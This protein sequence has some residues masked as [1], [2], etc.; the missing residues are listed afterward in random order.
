MVIEDFKNTK[1]SNT[2][3]SKNYFE[4]KTIF[5]KLSPAPSAGEHLQ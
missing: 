3:G 4:L 2:E 1:A 5:A